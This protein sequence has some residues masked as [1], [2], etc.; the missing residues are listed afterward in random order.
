MAH[1]QQP[2]LPPEA[3]AFAAQLVPM[4]QQAVDEVGTAAAMMALAAVAGQLVG[5]AAGQGAP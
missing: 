5:A 4:C 3:A 2:Q 1:P